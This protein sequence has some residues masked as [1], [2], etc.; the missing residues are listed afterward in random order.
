MPV[1]G[2]GRQAH[3]AKKLAQRGPSSG[4]SAKKLAQH[5]AKTPNLGCFECAGRTFS[6]LHDETPPL[7]ELFRARTHTRPSRATNIA[8]STQKHGDIETNNTTAHPQQ[9]TTETAITSAPKKCTKNAHFSPAKAITVSIPLRHKQAK[10]TMVS[11]PHRH[12]QAKAT[13]VSGHRATAPAAPT[14]GARRRRNQDGIKTT[15]RAKL[16]ARTARGRAAA[17][18]HA[19][20]PGPPAQ[21]NETRPRPVSRPR[22]R[23]SVSATPQSSGTASDQAVMSTWSSTAARP[24]SR[25]ATG[26]RNGEQDT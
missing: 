25:R 3:G 24:A 5:G 17:H 16:A 4:I 8:H 15:R 9:G 22:P 20:Q 26:T 6:R 10:A 23:H 2:S 18:G 21:H 1:D 13:A 19:Q 7:G 14:R 11:I 12:K